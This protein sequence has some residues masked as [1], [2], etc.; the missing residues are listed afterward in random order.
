MDF[1]EERDGKL[2]G[3]EIKW[4][5]KKIKIQKEWLNTYPDSSFHVIHRDNF[6]EWLT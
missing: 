2:Y 6:L 5:P 3:F 1:V 4:N